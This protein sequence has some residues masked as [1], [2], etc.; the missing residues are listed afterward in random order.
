MGAC[1]MDKNGK[2]FTSKVYSP[3]VVKDTLGAGYCFLAGTV[4]KLVQDCNAIESAIDYGC[5]VA[6]FKISNYGYDHIKDEFKTGI[7]N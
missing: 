3:E 4:H 2:I 6:G 5:R 1:A 7:F